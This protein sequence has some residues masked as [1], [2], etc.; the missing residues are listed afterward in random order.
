MASLLTM[1][2]A[3]RLIRVSPGR[4]YRVI[5]DGRPTGGT[6]GGLGKPTLV[7]LEALQAL[8]QLEGLQGPD[9]V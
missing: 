8:C 3:A 7:S 4:F 9:V 6:W 1:R 2:A 5:D